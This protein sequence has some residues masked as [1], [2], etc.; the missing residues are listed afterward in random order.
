MGLYH[1]KPDSDVY[2]YLTK[3]KESPEGRMRSVR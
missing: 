2:Y 3:L 1:I